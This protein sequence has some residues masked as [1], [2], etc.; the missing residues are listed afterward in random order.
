[1]KTLTLFILCFFS[2]CA[3]AEVGQESILKIYKADTSTISGKVVRFYQTIDSPCIKVQILKS[4]GDGVADSSLDFCSISG[5]NFNKDFAEIFLEKGE[6]SN[7]RLLLTLKLMPLMKDEDEDETTVCEFKVEN[8]KLSGPS[9][10]G[11]N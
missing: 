11:A 1:M 6:F 8:A 9:C 2:A 3:I 7:G 4:G 10:T 5:K